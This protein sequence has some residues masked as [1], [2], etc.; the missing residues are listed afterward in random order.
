MHEKLAGWATEL[1]GRGISHYMQPNHAAS[2]K[3]E[4]TNKSLQQ[5]LVVLTS[6]SLLYYH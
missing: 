1:L 4:C 3:Q 6:Q 5:A 2:H